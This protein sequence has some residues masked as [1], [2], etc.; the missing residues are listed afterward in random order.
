MAAS[1]DIFDLPWE[2][3]DDPATVLAMAREF[4][5]V[6]TDRPG[7]GRKER[8]R[9]YLGQRD[10][11]PV[12]VTGEPNPLDRTKRIPFPTRE[13][14]EQVLELIKAQ[15]AAGREV[16]Q[17]MAMLAP[18]PDDIQ[19]VEVWADRYVKQFEKKVRAEGRSH[20]TLRDIKGWARGDGHW[21]WWWGRDC[22][23]LTNG[24][25]LDWYDWLDERPKYPHTKNPDLKGDKI[26]SKTKK[27]A[28]DGFKV[29]LHWSATANATGTGL[30]WP[31]P[32][33][34]TISV[35]KPSTPTIPVERVLNILERI[36]Y[37]ERG[38]YL[39]IA[40]ES[41][42]F[43]SAAPMSIEDYRPETFEIHWHKG[44]QGQR[45]DAPVRG[46]KNRADNWREV[47]APP[48]RDWLAWRMDQV[49][50]SERLS[51]ERTA[52]FWHPSAWNAKKEW[53]DK[54]YRRKW[55]QAAA[56]AGEK[57]AP[58]AGTRHSILSTLAGILTPHALQ[59]HSQHA[60]LQSLAHYTVGA[61]PDTAAM[62]QAI[63]RDQ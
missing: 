55:H 41:V 48:L 35:T 25:V 28:V 40:F 7:K 61:K 45:L 10:G 52:L 32:H 26:G 37:E 4:G 17:V 22:R 19:M 16:P 24:D 13:R 31:L 39:A 9:I 42:R 3:P 36:P 38:I 53:N 30:A 18:T 60:S 46:Q 50:T 23:R 14:A 43:G 6:Y 27:N 33:F 58:Q 34:P 8:H 54:S 59:A 62:V 63:R 21:G 2:L 20:N 57:I 11:K 56:Q 1:A 44:R 49:T 29:M 5:E 51:G 47:W 12:Y 15:I